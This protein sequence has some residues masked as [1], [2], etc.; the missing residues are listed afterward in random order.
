M[1]PMIHRAFIPRFIERTQFF[2]PRP[3]HNACTFFLSPSFHSG[4]PDDLLAVVNRAKSIPS[5]SAKSP[6][7]SARM[8]S[9]SRWPPGV[10]GSGRHCGRP[11][12]HVNYPVVR[13]VRH[14]PPRPQTISS[15]ARSPETAA[16]I[17]PDFPYVLHGPYNLDPDRK[18]F[19]YGV[20]GRND[21]SSA[22]PRPLPPPAPRQPSPSTPAH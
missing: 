13:R 19:G 22:R 8:M 14:G 1:L 7:R 20:N 18:A 3:Q 16:V 6:P 12:W 10:C 9:C 11:F 4:G 21:P 5:S 2:H 17:N 15:S